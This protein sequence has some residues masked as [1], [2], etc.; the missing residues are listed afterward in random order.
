M[1]KIAFLYF[2]FFSHLI[3]GQTF[4]GTTGAIPDDGTTTDYNLTVAGLSSSTL[5]AV[6]GLIK[7]KLN[8]THTYDSDLNVALISPDG[9]LINLFSGIGGDGDNFTN[10]NLYQTAINSINDGIAPFSG[11]YRPQQSLGNLNNNQNGNGIWKLRIKDTYPMADAGILNSWSIQ[12]GSNASVVPV[13]STS[14]LPIVV[15]NTNNVPIE[16]EPEI[17]ATMGII[18]N[19]IGAINN[20]SDIPTDYNGNITIEYRGSYSQSLP[21]KPYKITT[22]DSNFIDA[23]V[24]LLGMPLE[25]DWC[26]IA[27]YNDKVFMRNALAYKLFGEMGNYAARNQF[28]EVVVNGIYQGV[29]LLMESLKRDNNRIDISKLETTEN[30]G[31]NLTGG[32]IFKNDYWDETNSWQLNYNPIDHPDFNVRLV[33]DYPKATVITPQQKIYIQ[34]FVNNFET[35]LYGQNFADE[36]LGYNAFIDI[37]SFIDYFIVNELSRNNDGFKKSCYFNKDKDGSNSISK[38]KAGPVWDFDWAWKN[39]DECSIF[40]ATDGSGWAHKINDCY[41]DNNSTGWYVRLLQDENF[42]NKLRCRWNELRTTFLSNNALNYYVDSTALYLNAAQSRHFVKWENLGVSTGAPEVDADPNTFAGQITK[43]KNWIATRVL[44]LDANIP[45]NASTCILSLNNRKLDLKLYPNPV[46]DL[47]HFDNNTNLKIDIVLIFDSTGKCVF[48][49]KFKPEMDL[50][51][52][53]NGIY[54]CKMINKSEIIRV[55][56]IVVL[57]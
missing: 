29:Y 26:L 18:S 47:L 39:I 52:L 23:N 51:S 41:P 5:N 40:A 27:N 33:Y 35:A 30:T 10:T 34:T 8:I 45:G 56:K 37:D 13:F 25:H 20:T 54:F 15:I 43:F 24:S 49:S 28:C 19:G 16:D 46:K 55:E 1:K 31:V 3:Y 53:S 57:H 38:I 6:H 4:N 17:N 21:Q 12:L 11:F 48:T 9:T 2:A 44:W 36:V 22:K 42:Q 14:N 32:Y 50:S 7:V